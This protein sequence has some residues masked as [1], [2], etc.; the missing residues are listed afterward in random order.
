MAPSLARS[1]L[2]QKPALLLALAWQV[3]YTTAPVVI[4][5]RFGSPFVSA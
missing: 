3:S 5:W 4:T 1:I 2:P